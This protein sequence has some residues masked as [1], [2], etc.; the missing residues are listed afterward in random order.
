MKPPP[1][2]MGK[3]HPDFGMCNNFDFLAVRT[4]T[5][6]DTLMCCIIGTPENINYLF[7]TNGKLMVLGVPILMGLKAC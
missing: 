4:L 2:I 6:I 7:G 1:L 3:L 5:A